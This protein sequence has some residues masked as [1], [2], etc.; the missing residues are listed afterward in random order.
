MRFF[1][2]D[3][4]RQQLFDHQN[5]EQGMLCQFPGLCLKIG[6]FYFLRIGTS[7]LEN[8]PGRTVERPSGEDLRLPGNGLADAPAH[9]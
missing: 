9:S 5:P 6:F 3:W 1:L 2:W 7:R 4:A 8:N